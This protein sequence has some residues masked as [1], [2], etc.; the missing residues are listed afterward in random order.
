MVSE[1]FTKKIRF[2][3]TPLQNNR[4]ALSKTILEPSVDNELVEFVLSIHLYKQEYPKNQSK[5]LFYYRIVDNRNYNENVLG[6]G[7]LETH[8]TALICQKYKL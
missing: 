4:Y 5:E 6:F 3:G 7:G 1:S 8:W 2:L